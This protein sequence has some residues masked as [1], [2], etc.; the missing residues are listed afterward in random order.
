MTERN[1]FM[2]IYDYLLEQKEKIDVN[3]WLIVVLGAAVILSVGYYGY[4]W[5][6]GNREQAAQ[7][8]LAECM[9]EF[10]SAQVGD[11]PWSSVEQLCKLG[12]QENSDT[13]C[14]PY[15]LLLQ[16]DAFAAQDKK[17]EALTALNSVLNS[18]SS[19][20]ELYPLFATKRALLM[21]D[22]ETQKDAGIEQLKQ[23]ANDTSNKQRDM[24][25]YY[26]GLY[27]WHNHEQEQAHKV[28]QELIAMKQ[29]EQSQSPWIALAQEKLQ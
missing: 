4:N 6:K 2:D 3:R 13:N 15:F 16:A 24:A 9:Q 22:I 29:S 18:L 5:Y 27:Y 21:L 26:L 10:A 14:A 12:Y 1:K 17:D 7:K 23:L 11:E 19:S 25:A 8:I 28:W 20:S